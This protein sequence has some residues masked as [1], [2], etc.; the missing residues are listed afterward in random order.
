MPSPVVRCPGALLIWV[1]SAT[2]DFT[3]TLNMPRTERLVRALG[4]VSEYIRRPL[5][6]VIELLV[7]H[8]RL[9]FLPT[10]HSWALLVRVDICTHMHVSLLLLSFGRFE[11]GVHH[12]LL[13]FLLSGNISWLAPQVHVRLGGRRRL[14]VLC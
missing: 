1:E 6:L 3:S 13:G 11:Q 14:H 9:S 10:H 12:D 7:G 5:S 4:A 2:R 8:I